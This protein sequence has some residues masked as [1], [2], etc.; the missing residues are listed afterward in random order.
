MLV[1]ILVHLIEDH[2]EQLTQSVVKELL[3]DARTPGYCK[4]GQNEAYARVYDV[5]HNLGTWLDCES[6]E[7]TENFYRGLGQARFA[8]G[9][10]L[11]EVVCA[12][13]LTEQAIRSFIDARGWVDSALDL[14]RQIE[15][16]DLITR[17]FERA[18]YFTVLSYEQ[19]ARPAIAAAPAA[20]VERRFSRGWFMRKSTHAA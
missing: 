13:M 1:T 2:A 4:L 14:R 12:L 9:I 15:L 11:A 3:T 20:R 19:Q 18:T 17:F 7:V 16:Y 5:L 8:E 6:D 10:P